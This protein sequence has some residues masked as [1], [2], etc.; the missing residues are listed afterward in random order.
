MM[1]PPL[2]LKCPHLFAHSPPCCAATALKGRCA[3]A[4][5]TPRCSAT[6]PA[7]TAA[8]P[9]R[10]RSAPVPTVSS[11]SRPHR[12]R[13]DAE[14]T[15]PPHGRLRRPHDP[16]GGARPGCTA[17][18]PA[19]DFPWDSTATEYQR[20]LHRPPVLRGARHAPRHGPRGVEPRGAASGRRIITGI[21]VPR[22]CEGAPCPNV[23][24]R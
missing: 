11:A 14:P 8:P 6:V 1:A 4:A 24:C 19:T 22:G 12:W 23:D 10:P 17:T 21:K 7:S 2:L 18:G 15:R 16:A 9:A 20:R 3:R 5:P 13:D